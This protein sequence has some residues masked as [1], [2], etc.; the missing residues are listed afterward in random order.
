M[1]AV[2]DIRGLKRICTACETRF[3]DMN[4]RPVVCPACDAEFTGEP[5]VKG[6]RG[7]ASSAAAKLKED[8]K[9]TSEGQVNDDTA[10]DEAD[11]D[12]LEDDEDDGVADVSFDDD[13]IGDL[14]D[15]D[16]TSSGSKVDLN[17]I[18]GGDLDD[19]E[20]MDDVS[21]GDDDLDDEDLDP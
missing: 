17:A 13:A 18:E 9:S 19:L 5:K 1:S 10:I 6:R 11:E 2:A 20:D 21:G 7:K 3:Y 16:T 15:G 4:K 14:D 12:D 8:Q